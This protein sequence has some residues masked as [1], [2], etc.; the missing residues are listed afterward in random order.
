MLDHRRVAA[1]SQKKREQ[2]FTERYESLLA[3]ALRL[4]NHQRDTAEDLVQ[5][6]FVQFMQSR[7][8][9]EEIGNIDGYLNRMLR[10][11]YFSRISRPPQHLF[12]TALSVAD[13]DTIQSGT[14][15]EPSRRVQASEDLYRLCAYACARKE[16]SKAGSV[17]ILRFFLD[18]FPIEI[19]RVLNITR[20]CVDE[21]QRKARREAKLFMSEPQRLRAADVKSALERHIKYQKSDRE[22]MFGLRRM[23]FDSCSG[24]CLSQEEFAEVYSNGSRVA[25]ATP[26]LAH[27][28]SCRKC[29]DSVNRILDLPLIADL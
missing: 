5:D 21:W 15:G 22:L 2:L 29:L 12:E 17:L 10:Y 24:E 19:A 23:I 14:A 26:K 20:H 11:M 4:T 6:A 16:S 25:L 13:Y 27:V 1:Q 8:K 3:W 7:T 18:Y 28:V 9:L